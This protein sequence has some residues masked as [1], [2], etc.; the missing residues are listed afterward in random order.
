MTR[1]RPFNDVLEAWLEEGPVIAPEDLLESAYTDIPVNHRQRRAFDVVG[2]FP[3][4]S[5]SVRFI[6]AAAA[7]V[8]IA[9]VGIAVFGRGVAPFDGTGASSSP[10]AT[11]APTDVLSPSPTVAATDVPSPTPTPVVTATTG[12]CDPANLAARITFWD[13]AA[14]HRIAT[15]ELT[16]SGSVACNLDSLDRPQLVDGNGAVLIDGEEPV[17][18]SQLSFNPGDTL[19]TLVQDGNYCGPTPVAPVTVAFVLP[20]GAGRFVASPL[21]PTDLNGVPPCSSTPGSAGSIEMHPWAP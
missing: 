2:R 17:G 20:D 14:G 16:N 10:T 21:S 15:V 11:V 5:R 6:A 18:S 12:M 4:F 7:V 13:G 3:L 8:L 1:S 19:T 9:F